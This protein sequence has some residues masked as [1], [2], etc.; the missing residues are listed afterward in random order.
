M[1]FSSFSSNMGGNQPAFSLAPQSVY[2]IR[3]TTASR[4][5]LPGI[6]YFVT[7]KFR[8]LYGSSQD[9]VFRVE[10]LV[11]A[12]F[13]DDLSTKCHQEREYK[14]RRINQVTVSP[15]LKLPQHPTTRR[16]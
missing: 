16:F 8:D 5:V 12:T 10:K 4:G 15:H 11:E 14:K 3:R 6:P 7:N 9:S 1:T 13:K 2:Q